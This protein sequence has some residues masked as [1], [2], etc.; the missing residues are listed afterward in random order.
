MEHSAASW[1]SVGAFLALGAAVAATV[2]TRT[3]TR[4]MKLTTQEKKRQRRMLAAT[5]RWE[6]RRRKRAARIAAREQ[7]VLQKTPGV[8][9]RSRDTEASFV[10]L[11]CRSRVWGHA[12]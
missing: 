2:R 3:L 4:A 8:V 5:K 6:K 7:A 9:I 12:V 10:A 1:A 11:M